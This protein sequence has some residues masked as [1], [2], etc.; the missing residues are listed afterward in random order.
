MKHDDRRRLL[1]LTW[2]GWANLLG[3]QWIGLRLAAVVEPPDDTHVGYTVKRWWPLAGWQ[4]EYRATSVAW[5][6]AV[7]GVVA[8]VTR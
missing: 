6:L 8:A 7:A 5:A 3:L 1:G 2:I 4:P